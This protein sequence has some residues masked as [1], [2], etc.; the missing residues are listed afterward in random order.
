M[1]LFLVGTSPRT[2]T[3][4]ALHYHR[5]Y[6]VILNLEGEGME[7]IGSREYPFFPGSIHIIPPE[8]P[9]QKR[10][11]GGFRD[12]YFRTDILSFDSVSLQ[13]LPSGQTPL[14]LQDD[15]DKTMEKLLSILLA[16]YLK[17]GKN[18]RIVNS[19]YHTILQ[20]LDEWYKKE[21]FDPLI[22]RIIHSITISFNDPEFSVTEAL[23]E[24]GFS[25][26]YIRRC[27]HAAT[28]VTPNAYLTQIRMN[29]AAQLLSQKESL[30]LS[31]GDIASM[32]GY[33]DARYFSRIFKKTFGVSP[34]AYKQP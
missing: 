16:R 29:Y 33:Y 27:F 34:S 22:D 1:A 17:A 20:L 15:G 8:V 11:E 32:C 6:E 5:H 31:M 24:T 13:E 3:T 19:M 14:I 30:N 10:A 18:D 12:I 4:Y 28:G 23:L 9:H 25:K 26:D 7:R 2:F 21:A